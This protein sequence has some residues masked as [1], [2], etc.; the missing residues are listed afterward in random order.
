MSEAPE[1]LEAPRY[2]VVAQTYLDKLYE[3]GQTVVFEGVPNRA[4][5]PL[6]EAAEFAVLEAEDGRKARAGRVIPGSPASFETPPHVAVVAAE[7][8]ALEVQVADLQALLTAAGET[9]A[10]KNGYI[11]EYETDLANAKADLATAQAEVAELKAAIK[12]LDGDGDGKPGGA[13]KKGA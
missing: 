2:K 4:L 1:A 12:P 9:I 8:V 5:E 7:V 10:E 11:Q 3:P 13:A 6:N